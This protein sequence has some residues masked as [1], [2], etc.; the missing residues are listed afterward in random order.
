MKQVNRKD[1]MQFVKYLV[2]GVIN[3][4]VTLILIYVCKSII[5]VNLWVS[6]FIGYVVGVINSFLWNKLWVFHS[7]SHGWQ[8]EC[9]KFLVGFALCYG[10]QFAAT[11]LLTNYVIY[12][13]F[14]VSAFGFAVSGYGVATVI[15]MMV[16]T[17]A[18]YIYN[19]L[20]TFRQISM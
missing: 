19:R 5:G 17:I 18:N 16:Y 14:L 6:N 20:V 4:L 7:R 1:L 8:V 12:D 10:L 2:V 11:W 9:V 13:D 3:T 15:G